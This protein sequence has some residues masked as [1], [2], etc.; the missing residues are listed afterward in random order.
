MIRDFYPFNGKK[1]CLD[2]K[3]GIA[4]NLDSENCNCN[5]SLINQ[6]RIYSSDY[7]TLNIRRHSKYKRDCI[8]CI[9]KD[10]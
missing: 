1:Y 8:Y 9:K 3:N 5:I 2:L 6:N 10:R 4:H 7:Y